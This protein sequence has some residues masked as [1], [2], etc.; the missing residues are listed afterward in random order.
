MIYGKSLGDSDFTEYNEMR[1]LIFENNNCLSNKSIFKDIGG[2]EI[3][4]TF[5][6]NLQYE[7]G[8]DFDDEDYEEV[9]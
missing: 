9:N 5:K 1:E 8:D 4:E 3:W 6:N 7:G 2:I